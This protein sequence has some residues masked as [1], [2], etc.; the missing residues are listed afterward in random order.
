MNTVKKIFF[1]FAA[2]VFAV[3]APFV[4]CVQAS[5]AQD[6]GNIA[7]E[8]GIDTSGINEGLTPEARA[9]LQENG[10][11]ADNPEAISQ[12]T[13]RDV[14]RYVWEEFK[15]SLAKPLKLLVSLMAII[16]VAAVIEGK[17]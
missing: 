14:F 1:I 5:A 8:L 6:S 15:S 17:P 11:T 13:P 12:I 7:D 10:L 4:P 3:Y 2:A 16:L 9:V